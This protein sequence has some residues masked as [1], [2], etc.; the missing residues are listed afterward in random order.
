MEDCLFCKI[1]RG[2][3]PSK[4]VAE[5]DGFLAFEDIDP[6]AQQHVLVIPT[7]HHRNFDEYVAA[8]AGSESAMLRFVRDTADRMGVAGRYRLITNV[9]EQ[10][11]QAVHHLHWHILAGDDLPGF[12]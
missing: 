11:G 4:K 1:A 7:E 10:A 6:K 3:L 8:D 5:A 2:E 12:H 9:G